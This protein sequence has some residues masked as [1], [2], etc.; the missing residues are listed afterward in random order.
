ML[1]SYRTRKVSSFGCVWRK[2]D[3]CG[4]GFGGERF[5]WIQN[6]PIN[7]NQALHGKDVQGTNGYL[8]PVCH[9]S[10]DVLILELYQDCVVL[11]LVDGNETS[12]SRSMW[13]STHPSTHLA[14]AQTLIIL[15][16]QAAWQPPSTTLQASISVTSIGYIYISL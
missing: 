13:S 11:T 12:H 4:L 8:P 15:S 16:L 14:L 9:L 10:H 6:L 5:T 1:S 7:V 2:I 3:K